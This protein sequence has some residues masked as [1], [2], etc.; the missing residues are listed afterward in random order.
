M[1]FLHFKKEREIII[2][3][4]MS[5]TPQ[6]M[7]PWKGEK[8]SLNLSLNTGLAMLAQQINDKEYDYR[9]ELK[10][11]PDEF[12][13]FFFNCAEN[14]RIGQLCKPFGSISSKYSTKSETERGIWNRAFVDLLAKEFGEDKVI[15]M[16]ESL[17]NRHKN[18]VTSLKHGFLFGLIKK[19]EFK[20]VTLTE[21]TTAPF[22]GNFAI[23][24]NQIGFNLGEVIQLAE[25]HTH[26]RRTEYSELP[27][28]MVDLSKHENKDTLEVLDE[29]SAPSTEVPTCEDTNE[30]LTLED[31][32]E[33]LKFDDSEL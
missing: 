24:V 11:T 15:G 16:I 1:L 21:K 28:E 23:A 10:L 29:E 14:N 12:R 5:V 32:N 4:G 18:M 13:S 3:A 20:Q 33:V 26:F 30:V 27:I 17:G 6:A 8:H 19:V 31:T 25:N 9:L 7:V 22:V 2:M